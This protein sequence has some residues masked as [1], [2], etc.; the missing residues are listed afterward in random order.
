[1]ISKFTA[2]ALTSMVGATLWID[3][4]LAWNPGRGGGHGGGGHGPSAAPEL[5]GTGALAVFALLASV[6][7]VL[8]NRTRNK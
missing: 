5:D 8:F 3:Q 1:M 7:V 4:A 2:Y 6:A